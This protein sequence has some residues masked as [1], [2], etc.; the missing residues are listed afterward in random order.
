MQKEIRC[1]SFQ[2]TCSSQSNVK[3]TTSGGVV[4]GVLENKICVGQAET[5]A[6]PNT[7]TLGGD[8]GSNCGSMKMAGF[9]LSDLKMKTADSVLPALCALSLSCPCTMKG[10]F[11]QEIRVTG[12]VR[13]C[14]V[15]GLPWGSSD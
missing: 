7:D 14:Q 5:Q 11:Q 8:F 1:C 9:P 4:V 10:C 3:H 6:E 15:Q 2:R 12:D 13:R